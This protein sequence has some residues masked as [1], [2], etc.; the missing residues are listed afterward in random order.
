MFE[1]TLRHIQDFK[2]GTDEDGLANAIHRKS[3]HHPTW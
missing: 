3:V 1:D 2:N